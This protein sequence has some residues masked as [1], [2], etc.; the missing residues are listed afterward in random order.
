MKPALKHFVF[1][2]FGIGI[3]DELWLSYR[4]EI[5]ANTVLPSLANQSNQG[6][7][8]VIFIDE[9]LPILHRT[10]LEQLLRDTGLNARTLQVSDYSMV[11]REIMQ[12]IKNVEVTTLITSRIDD[13]DCIH[14]SVIELIQA[15]ATSEHN[16]SE[17]LLISLKNGLEFLPSDECYRPVDY[18]TLALAL[19]MVDK[20]IG[21]KAHVITQ[22]AHHLVVS[23]LEQQQISAEHIHLTREEPL[24]LYTKHPLSDSY[25]FGA[26]ARI[27]W[28]PESLKG[29]DPSLFARFGLQPARLEYLS[30]LLRQSPLGM[31]HK[32]LEKLNNVR[33]QLRAEQKSIDG[34]DAS[35]VNGLLSKKARLEIK[36][37][38]PNPVKAGSVKVRV[39][40]LGSSASHNLF[41][42]QKKALERFEVCFYMSQSSVISYMAPP[43]LDARFS[44]EAKDAEAYRVQWDASKEHWQ[45]LEQSRPDIVIVDFF[46][47]SIGI[48]TFGTSI[49]TASPLMLKTLTKC[50]IDYSVQAPWSEEAKRLRAWALPVFLDRVASLCPN[51]FV[52]QA[53]WASQY[54]SKETISSFA[55][56]TFESLIDLNNAIIDPML[57][58]LDDS[59][60][61]VERVGGKD[62]GLIA[63][64]APR[65][66]Y[67]PYHY[68]SS[69]YRTIAKQ[70]FAKM[71]QYV[72]KNEHKWAFCPYYYHGTYYSTVAKQLLAR[73][74]N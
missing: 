36:A 23:T 50:G 72:S 30:K 67:C 35:V 54:K 71:V 11:S 16:I 19:T 1:T 2:N 47:E 45:Q 6:F 27:L 24:Y 63:G 42:F 22:Y 37:S 29:F 55:G 33:R 73:V 3:K 60:V 18:D 40:I 53:N 51:I 62:A 44:V 9:A 31:P 59:T 14:E 48:A 26:R 32:Y 8:W 56:S 12:L 20:T 52:H 49:V 66:A 25:F 5:F 57:E 21:P 39:A 4:L 46:D 43:C 69:Y 58:S 10:R 7:E 64:G 15:E 68:D 61:P 13:D 34:P 65:W 28:A 38:R 74:I 41:K 70:A 17:V